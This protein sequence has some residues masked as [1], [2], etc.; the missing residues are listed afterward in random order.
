[1]KYDLTDKHSIVWTTLDKIDSV[2][3][4][5]GFV[6]AIFLLCIFFSFYF[7]YLASLQEYFYLTG[8]ICLSTAVILG[9]YRLIKRRIVNY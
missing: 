5:V 9:A 8:Y 3:S 2:L 6:S 7:D 1:M 4:V